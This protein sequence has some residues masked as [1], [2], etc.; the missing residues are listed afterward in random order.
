LLGTIVNTVAILA[1][2]FAGIL[3]KGG[4]PAKYSETV[5]HSIALAVIL[6]GVKGALKSDDILIVI[7]SLATGSVMGEF[8]KIEDKIET[9]G[10]TLQKLFSKTGDGISKGFVTSSLLFCVGSMA[11][12]GSLESGLT[13][14]HQTLFA[15]SMLDG[16][17]SVILA[18]TLGIGV[19]FSAASVLLYQG[20]V[21]LTSSYAKQFLVPEV[22]AQMSSTGGILIA[23]IGINM[24]E[25]KRIKVG[26]MLPAI[27]IPLLYFI[28]KRALTL[29]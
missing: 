28:F 7:I 10:N 27:F 25:I 14:N 2:S 21:T 19:F 20:A 26:N 6:I 22:I 4:I 9:I 15:K 16:I 23:A 29:I 13:G 1:G 5:M 24:L 12:V 11:I 17:G 3:L 8:L 18:S